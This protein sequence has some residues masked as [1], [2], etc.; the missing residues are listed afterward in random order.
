MNTLI[1]KIQA[2]R[3]EQ[4]RLRQYLLRREQSILAC[5]SAF[6]REGSALAEN[7]AVTPLYVEL[8]DRELSGALTIRNQGGESAVVE[9][10]V[11][12]WS[13]RDGRDHYAHTTEV[14]ATPEFFTIK[15]GAT[16][17]VRVGMRR[18]LDPDKELSYRIFLQE[19]PVGPM[20]TDAIAKTTLRV[21]LPLFV[22]PLALRRTDVRWDLISGNQMGMTVRATNAGTV[23]TQILGFKVL[24]AVP[25]EP[26]LTNYDHAYLLPG[27][28]RN[29]ALNGPPNLGA[30]LFEH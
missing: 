18:G 30:D 14:L 23:H 15:G 2:L 28:T 24:P 8:S 9:V 1:Q 22:S 21:A 7:F 16:Q 13:Q 29:W 3:L 19:I 4:T 6:S 10:Q 20:T 27:Q 12:K 25:A 5:T 17:I 11:M 26:V